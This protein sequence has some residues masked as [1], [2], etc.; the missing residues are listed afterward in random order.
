MA[1]RKYAPICSIDGCNTAHHSKG[2]CRIHYRRSQKGLDM[3]A[4]PRNK[5]RSLPCSVDGCSK[6]Y[7]SKGYCSMHYSRKQRGTDINAIPEDRS[8]KPLE[9]L[10]NLDLTVTG[11]IRWPFAMS[12]GYGSLKAR[13]KSVGA[14]RYALQYH[15]GPPASDELQA[16]HNC[17]NSW[18]VNPTHLRWATAKENCSDRVTHGTLSRGEHRPGTKLR[19]SDVV[20]IIESEDDA[21]TL[22][23]RHGVSV[24]SIRGIKKGRKWRHLSRRNLRQC[25]ARNVPQR[26]S[27]MTLL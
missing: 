17:G 18:C 8:S 15:S 9:F 24:S 2:Y 19:E 20:R 16:A 7:A 5:L 4:P 27:Q 3:L 21:R 13:G 23:H 6:P 10:E 25:A 14:H 11:C 1:G 22:A 12:K 26:E